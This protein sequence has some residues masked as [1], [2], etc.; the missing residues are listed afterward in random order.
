MLAE[1]RVGQMLHNLAR[2]R[3]GEAPPVQCSRQAIRMSLQ[4]NQLFPRVQTLQTHDVPQENTMRSALGRESSI[5]GEVPEEEF[6]TCSCSNLVPLMQF[7]GRC[8]CPHPSLPIRAS[9]SDRSSLQISEEARTFLR[10]L[11]TSGPLEQ[12]GPIQ[13]REEPSSGQPAFEPSAL[14]R[15]NKAAKQRKRD[16]HR[17]CA[18]GP[19]A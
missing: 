14:S 18:N 11:Q 5:L 12:E 7:C 6:W 10:A 2:D 13:I 19:S 3:Q 9:I 15:R 1:D 8:G 4:T 17:T 16:R